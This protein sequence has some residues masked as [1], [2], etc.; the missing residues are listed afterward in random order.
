MMLATA[1]IA[2]L[3][4]YSLGSAQVNPGWAR[5]THRRKVL[6]PTRVSFP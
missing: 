5:V 6:G 4:L 2:A 3:Q 1:R